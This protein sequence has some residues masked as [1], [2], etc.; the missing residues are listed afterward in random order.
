[1]DDVVENPLLKTTD[2]L[3]VTIMSHGKEGYIYCS[4]GR[5][6]KTELILNK[7]ACVELKDKPKFIIFQACRGDDIDVRISRWVQVDD[8][9][10]TRSKS[11]PIRKATRDP[12]WMDMLIVYSSVP[13]YQSHRDTWYGSWFIESLVRVFMDYACENELKL[14]LR[15][16]GKVMNE[17]PHE[18]GHK[19]SI[20]IS[21][22]G[23]HKILY[24]NP[25]L[26]NKVNS[27]KYPKVT[28]KLQTSVRNPD[29]RT[30]EDIHTPGLTNTDH[31]LDTDMRTSDYNT[32]TN[33]RTPGLTNTNY[34]LESRSYETK[35]IETGSHVICLQYDEEKIVA[36]LKNG[37][38]KIYNKL[39]L[40]LEHVIQE[41]FDTVS[42]LQ[43]SKNIL[44]SGSWDKTVKIWSVIMSVSYVLLNTLKLDN[45]VRSLK[46]NFNDMLVTGTF[47]GELSAWKV[48]SPK[49]IK[50]TKVLH[51][52][53]Y[54]YGCVDFDDTHIVN[55]CN[56]DI[57]VWSTRSLE[58]VTTMTGHWV[59]VLSLQIC[60][61]T[62]VSGS[63]DTTVRIWDMQTG[64]CFRVLEGHTG[65]VYCVKFDTERIISASWDGYIK[66]W[67]HK[68]ALDPNIASDALCIR[69]FYKH[70]W[71]VN[72]LQFDYTQIVSGSSDKTII[73]RNFQS[74]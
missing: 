6:I 53:T 17:I 15:D 20:E 27:E 74:T 9:S 69:T 35:K 72:C 44:L 32:N 13:G 7:F 48:N 47:L 54:H 22:C 58:Q 63:I 60:K 26:N 39:T 16:V 5:K 70:K 1:M 43:F 31:N 21:I 18:E 11:C 66:I 40:K 8:I 33:I 28:S 10:H 29:Q 64:H 49:D 65:S 46:Y 62:V 25:G 61:Q 52:G 51:S 19:Q 73:I 38:I 12:K 24:F 45:G 41:H 14:L 59:Y 50:K 56:K 3:W 71:P 23:F 4:D 30:K 57:Q 42:C 34:N 36:G 37:E 68:E 2:M 67:K 55:G